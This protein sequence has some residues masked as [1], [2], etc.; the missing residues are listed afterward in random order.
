MTVKYEKYFKFYCQQE[1]DTPP[2]GAEWGL[3]ETLVAY[4]SQKY[5][6]QVEIHGHA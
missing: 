3:A 6:S 1:G 4:S 2:C 5:L